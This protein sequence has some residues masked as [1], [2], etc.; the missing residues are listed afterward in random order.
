MYNIDSTLPYSVSMS[1][2][3]R[4][5]GVQG[6]Y[7]LPII[8]LLFIPLRTKKDILKFIPAALYKICYYLIIVIYPLLLLLA[9][10]WGI[11]SIQSLIG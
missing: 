10:Y 7:F 11:G 2:L 6:R 5:E 9:R 3:P 4:I 1:L 8:P